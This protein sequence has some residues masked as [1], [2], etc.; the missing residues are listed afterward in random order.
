[1]WVW[2]WVKY[3]QKMHIYIYYINDLLKNSFHLHIR[4]IR[5]KKSLKDHPKF[6]ISLPLKSLLEPFKMVAFGIRFA[7]TIIITIKRNSEKQPTI[8][9]DLMNFFPYFYFYFLFFYYFYLMLSIASNIKKIN[10]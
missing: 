3:W 7:Y 8:S 10:S 2:R 6:V 1:M 5:K 9:M 4:L